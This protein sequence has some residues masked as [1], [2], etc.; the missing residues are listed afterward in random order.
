MKNNPASRNFN[1]KEPQTF[2]GKLRIR[3]GF[4][5]RCFRLDIRTLLA[6]QCLTD[7]FRHQL[8]SIRL[9][10]T[11]PVGW[12]TYPFLEHLESCELSEMQIFEWGGGN[13]SLMWARKGRMV[14]TVESS[15]EW[16]EYVRNQSS[17]LPNLTLLYAQ[18]HDAYIN[19]IKDYSASDI[20][21]IDGRWRYDCAVAAVSSIPVTSLII[22]DN[23][24]WCPDTC[25]LL[26]SK[27]YSRFDFPGFGPSNQFTWC[28]SIFFKD[29]NH[30]LLNPVRPPFSLGC[31][32]AEQAEYMFVGEHEGSL[33]AK[34][35]S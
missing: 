3:F 31:V 32:S 8:K 22:V 16:I 33:A 11:F 9:G 20:I 30:P 6:C 24:E 19:Y 14:V 12:Y 27:G 34:D 28:T 10:N 29:L 35:N 2:W 5:Y 15:A 23:S 26:Q 17:Y 4:S 13:S 18:D 1:K 25:S 21:V 7:D